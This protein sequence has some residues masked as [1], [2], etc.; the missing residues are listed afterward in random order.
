MTPQELHILATAK[1]FIQLS[2]TQHLSIDLSPENL[3]YAADGTTIKIIDF[4]EEPIEDDER[5]CIF[6]KKVREDWS[7]HPEVQDYLLY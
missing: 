3:R 1:M 7:F 4:G 2:M 6:N 5:L